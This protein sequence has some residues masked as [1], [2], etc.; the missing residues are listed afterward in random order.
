LLYQG[1]LLLLLL[2]LLMCVLLFC[3]LQ[4]VGVCVQLHS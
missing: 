3:E 2:L 1:T 4:R